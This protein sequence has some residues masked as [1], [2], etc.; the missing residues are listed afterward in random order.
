MYAEDVPT[1]D[2]LKR[3]EFDGEGVTDIAFLACT[4][5]GSCV[6][7]VYSNYSYIQLWHTTEGT[8]TEAAC[9]MEGYVEWAVFSP[10]GRYVLSVEVL[11]KPV[12]D[13]WS[14]DT[15][16]S[17]TEWVDVTLDTW[18]PVFSSTGPHLSFLSF[19]T[20]GI[21]IHKFELQCGQLILSDAAFVPLQKPADPENFDISF[22]SVTYSPDEQFLAS[23]SSNRIYFT[24]T[25]THA[26]EREF[27]LPWYDSYA[28]HA[29]SICYSPDGTFL[30]AAT[31]TGH[32]AIWNANGADDRLS[33]FD[34]ED[35]DAIEEVVFS[36]DNYYLV[37]TC[38]DGS[39]AICSTEPDEDEAGAKLDA[40]DGWIR[41]NDGGLLLW[42]PVQ[43]RQSLRQYGLLRIAK[44]G[45]RVTKPTVHWKL[46]RAV[47]KDWRC[48]LRLD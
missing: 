40:V 13:L 32:I 43:Y 15:G 24:D 6:A 30:A 2:V 42:V 29:S 17:I 38:G 37:A 28:G 20:G 14:V 23:G 21:T 45:K 46:L 9:G 16:E 18:K 33:T 47:Q 8:C 25:T 4:P 22:S 12:W 44:D 39:I 5:D 35:V 19:G 10:D 34:I 27:T 26:V 41:D 1:G 31:K 3:V 48:M 36:P 11:D 7:F